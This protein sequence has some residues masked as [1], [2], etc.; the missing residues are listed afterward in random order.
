VCSSASDACW[1]SI[2]SRLLQLAHPQAQ[3]L[4]AGAADEHVRQLVL[5]QLESSLVVGVLAASVLQPPNPGLCKQQADTGS[6]SDRNDRDIENRGGR[7]EGGHRHC[8]KRA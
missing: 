5:H 2:A 4:H 8:T 6:C 1:S 3:Q 7:V